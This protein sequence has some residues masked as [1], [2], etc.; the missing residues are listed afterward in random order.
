MSAGPTICQRATIRDVSDPTTIQEPLFLPPCFQIHPLN[1][2]SPQFLEYGSSGGKELERGLAEGLNHMLLVLK[3]GMNGH[4]G[5]AECVDLV[6]VPGAFQRHLTYASLEPRLMTAWPSRTSTG[7]GYLQGPLGQHAAHIGR[8][9]LQPLHTGPRGS[10]E[11]STVSLTGCT[12][13]LI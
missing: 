8:R 11:N 6:T 9:C 2:A 1:L 13:D 3:P 4:H 7:K 5:L 12:H 10:R